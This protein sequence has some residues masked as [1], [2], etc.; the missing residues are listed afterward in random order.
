MN[1][2][3]I[4]LLVLVLSIFS[5]CSKQELETNFED[6]SALNKELQAIPLG[7]HTAL[8]AELFD[9][10]NEH[11]VNM[12]LNELIFES[13]TYYY[14]GKHNKYMISKNSISHDKFVERAKGITK[15]TGAAHVAENVARNYYDMEMVLEAWIASKSHRRALEGD[16]THSAV[17]ISE[18]NEG[19]LYFTQMFYR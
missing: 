2:K 17:N 15:R 18:N 16:Y 8:E 4:F 3:N 14:A 11:R 10:I 7:S 5:S 6:D 13:T 12:G 1:F 9:L 19:N